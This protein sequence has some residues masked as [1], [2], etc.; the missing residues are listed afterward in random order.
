MGMGEEVMFL[1][2]PAS[3]EGL[4]LPEPMTRRATIM[5]MRALTSALLSANA[6]PLIIGPG[7]N[8]SLSVSQSSGRI[9]DVGIICNKGKIAVYAGPVGIDYGDVVLPEEGRVRAL[10]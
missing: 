3:A 6:K 10:A 9:Q 2:L 8:L 7:I 4:M 5:T 1:R